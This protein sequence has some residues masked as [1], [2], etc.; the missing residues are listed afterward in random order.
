MNTSAHSA[1]DV[2]ETSNIPA[3]TLDG[4]VRQICYEL[5]TGVEETRFSLE[6]QLKEVV[7]DD[8]RLSLLAAPRLQHTCTPDELREEAF[9]A[10]CRF[11]GQVKKYIKVAAETLWQP[12]SQT[13]ETGVTEATAPQMRIVQLKRAI[14]RHVENPEHMIT[15]SK[16]LDELLTLTNEH[17][18]TEMYENLQRIQGTSDDVYGSL[19]ALNDEIQGGVE[20]LNDLSSK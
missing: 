13:A 7:K 12:S 3:E 17:F 10:G 5:Q 16:Q 8:I 9:E 15:V 14:L 1:S 20:A 4:I 11:V 18:H 6:K 2:N 19:E